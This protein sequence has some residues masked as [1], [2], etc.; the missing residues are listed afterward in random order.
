MWKDTDHNNQKN[1]TE[2]DIKYVTSLFAC[3]PALFGKFIVKKEGVIT[4]EIF[5]F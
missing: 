3:L 1:Q 2:T 4:R 5:Q